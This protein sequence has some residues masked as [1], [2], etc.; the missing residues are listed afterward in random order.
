[1]LIPS[2]QLI[3]DNLMSKQFSL[4]LTSNY[5]FNLSF[6]FFFSFSTSPLYNRMK[7]FNVRIY[8]SLRLNEDWCTSVFGNTRQ[9]DGATVPLTYFTFL[10]FFSLNF[11][12]HLHRYII[13]IIINANATVTHLQKRPVHINAIS[14]KCRSR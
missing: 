2:F 12:F 3:D 7:I 11:Y 1:M 10:L 14:S 8:Y 9:T 5:T 13:N 6:F 4:I